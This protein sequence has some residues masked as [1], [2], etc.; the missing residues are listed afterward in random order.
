[1]HLTVFEQGEIFYFAFIFGV[2]LGLYYDLYRMLRY[3]GLDSRFAIISQDIFFMCTS[4]ILSF[5]FAQAT[6]NGH[7]RGFVMI[8]HIFGFFSYRYS[9]GIMSGY[10]FK[11]VQFLIKKV[12]MFLSRVSDKISP[13][14]HKILSKLSVADSNILCV[15]SPKTIKRK[16]FAIK[17]K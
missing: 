11:F 13:F 5:L 16:I 9:I 15:L 6:V 1:M 2:A 4:S 7:F 8:G 12:E 3:L 10:V 14:I 17:I